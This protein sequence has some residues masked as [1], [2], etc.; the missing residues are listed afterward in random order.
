MG[1]KPLDLVKAPPELAVKIDAYINL[2]RDIKRKQRELQTLRGPIADFGKKVRADRIASGQP[3]ESFK[4]EGHATAVSYVCAE[5]SGEISLEEFADLEKEFGP[6]ARQL[7]ALDFYGFRLDPFVLKENLNLVLDT[8]M[9]LPNGIGQKILKP[10]PLTL[11]KNWSDFLAGQRDTGFI[12]RVLENFK[13][14]VKLQD[15]G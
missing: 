1:D 3:D 5:D 10:M 9:R 11:K 14:T 7:L 4:L 12:V 13:A 8:I 2:L 6:L 15:G